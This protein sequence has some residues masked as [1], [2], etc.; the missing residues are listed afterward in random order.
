MLQFK[1]NRSICYLFISLFFVSIIGCGNSDKS[2][3]KT[4]D[5]NSVNLS[6]DTVAVSVNFPSE[7]EVLSASSGA[8]ITA[9]TFKNRFSAPMNF[10]QIRMI[11]AI[12]TDRSGTKHL[13]GAATFSEKPDGS[14]GKALSG[15][16]ESIDVNDV[17]WISDVANSNMFF[18]YIHFFQ[19]PTI[20][21]G[22]DLF[23][24]GSVTL[25]DLIESGAIDI[26]TPLRIFFHFERK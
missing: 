13:V 9:G 24:G 1:L 20:E 2:G 14:S 10:D 23:N 22:I 18:A 3:S 26:R 16:I 11:R 19:T 15:N 21:I 8:S 6:Q 25:A 17:I 5:L 12:V 4:F 7:Q